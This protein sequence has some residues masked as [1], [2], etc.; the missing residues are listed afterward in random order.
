MSRWFPFVSLSAGLVLLVG[1][2][3]GASTDDRSQAGSGSCAAILEWKG[4]R[5]EGTGTRTVVAKGPIIGT[6]T[7]VGCGEQPGQTVARIEGVD[8]AD[9][10]AIPGTVGDIFLASRLMGVP[11]SELPTELAILMAGHPCAAT[12]PL[13]IEG[14]WIGE[15][16]PHDGWSWIQLTA[17]GGNAEAESYVG[18]VMDFKVNGRTTGLNEPKEWRRLRFHGDRVRVRAECV[19]G[20]SAN[21][22]FLA[23]NIA[24]ING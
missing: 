5:Y 19:P 15:M 11:E 9:A 8:P 4:T 21:E 7:L 3:G 16:D 2:C 6:G 24:L 22:T 23:T 13:V 17:N 10:L 1:A 20:G 18:F 12:K 14:R